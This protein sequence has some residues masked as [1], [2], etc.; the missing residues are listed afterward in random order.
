MD[1]IEAQLGLMETPNT[2]HKDAADRDKR[3]PTSGDVGKDF[4]RPASYATITSPSDAHQ[5]ASQRGQISQLVFAMAALHLEN[6]KT[7]ET[8]KKEYEVLDP[9]S[10]VIRSQNA[11]SLDDEYVFVDRCLCTSRRGNSIQSHS[12][13]QS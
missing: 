4:F 10:T 7:D 1:V 13:S 9:N 6:R 12:L 8:V 2:V 11:G 3:F 5:G